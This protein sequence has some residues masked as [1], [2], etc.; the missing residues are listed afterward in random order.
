MLSEHGDGSM[1]PTTR[2]TLVFDEFSIAKERGERVSDLRGELSAFAEI[3]DSLRRDARNETILPQTYIIAVS[4]IEHFRSY[5]EV[6]G[7]NT[8]IVTPRSLV[9][10][11]L[12]ADPPDWLTDQDICH[13]RLLDFPAPA[14][15]FDD[16]WE[17][18]IASWLVPGIE[19]AATLEQWFRIVAA[20]EDRVTN[21]YGSGPVSL[22]IQNQ[23]FNLAI[24]T[25][26]LA[27]HDFAASLKSELT[28]AVSPVLFAKKWIRCKALLPLMSVS[29]DAPLRLASVENISVRDRQMANRLPLTFPLPGQMHEEVSL[30]FCQALQ[31][32]RIREQHR[33]SDSVLALNAVW[34]GVG[35]EIRTWLAV[36]PKGLNESAADHLI[37]LPG[38][39]SNERIRK[40]VDRYRPPETVGAWPGITDQLQPW[41]TDYAEY[42]RSCFLRRDLK[43]QSDPS[44][45]F[46]RWLKDHSTVCFDHH[47]YSYFRVAQAVQKA[48]STDRTVILVM[49]DAL[50]IHLSADMVGYLS[51]SLGE[52]PTTSSCMFVPL[53]TVT[54]VCKEAVL[55]GKLPLE[56]RGDLLPQLQ[57]RYGL[58]AD[59]VCISSNWQDAE[60][61]QANADT[62]L[63][64]YRD[65]RLDDQLHK[66]V[67]YSAML[68][69]SQGVFL[70][71]SRLAKRWANDFRC[72]NQKYPL[73]ILTADHGFTFGPSP[74]RETVGHRVLDGAHR[75][76]AIDGPISDADARDEAMTVID[77][78]VFRL[79]SSYLAAKGRHF[80]RGTMSGWSMS[81][82]GLLP[83]EAIVPFV[84]WFGNEE[85]SPWPTVVFAE[86]AYV[87]RNRF[88]FT[89]N[90]KNTKS[91]PT[92]ACTFRVCIAGEDEKA[93]KSIDSI[94][95]GKSFACSMELAVGKTVGGDTVPINVTIRGRDRKSGEMIEY[96][97]D[98]LVPRKKL[99]VEKTNDQDDFENMF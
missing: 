1:N 85:T 48:L 58:S 80:G 64:V 35:E 86:G 83:E 15:T 36:Y 11:Q 3:N 27:P 55:L 50:A 24:A 81:H 2:V 88:H 12:N 13:W 73:V 6:K 9:S 91:V 66:L 70:Q 75:C 92:L 28:R 65:N 93:V 67:S 8:R 23:F 49:V 47:E 4:S 16:C 37:D 99:L 97:D 94:A 40:I 59:E 46:S 22:W 87:E 71:I 69:D 62:R 18:T 57:K 95:A 10:E 90:F 96:S 41:V 51:D 31:R 21:N 14:L 5:R 34:Q 79:R 45:G 44:H 52:Q 20:A 26:E 68:E 82:G 39:A 30:L 78:D 98:F 53:P 56:C 32:E 25:E 42:I 77:K 61:F 54:E 17:A 29:I 76:I 89:I 84:Q 38:F 60:R 43:E 72:I 33:L 74:G 7:V 63:V 19:A